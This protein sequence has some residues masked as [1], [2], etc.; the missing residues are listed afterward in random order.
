MLFVGVSSE[1]A[2]EEAKKLLQRLNL[3]EYADRYPFEL[4]GGQQQ[5]VGIA[6]AIAN[7]PPIIVADEPLGNLDSVNAKNV[8]EFLKELNE[9]DG[10]TIIMVTHEAWSLRDAKTIFHMKD[11]VMTEV[12][13]PKGNLASSLTE[14]L[15]KQLSSVVGGEAKKEVGQND[16]VGKV[17]EKEGLEITGGQKI[18]GINTE[19]LSAPVIANFL[20]RGYSLDE[21]N[22]FES[23]VGKLFAKE[24]SIEEFHKLI[25]KSYK[26]EGVGLWKKKAERIVKYLDE[27]IS[28][29]K[30]IE[31]I[32]KSIEGNVEVSIFD[33][34][35]NIRDWLVE[36]YTGE[37]SPMQISAL[38]Q[39]ISDRIRNLINHDDAV[40]VLSLSSKKFGVGLSLR[41]SH[42]IAEKLE[43]ILNGEELNK[44]KK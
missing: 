2:D 17:E 13:H 43:L 31:E 33:E 18:E 20:L 41:A 21:I 44:E 14:H 27:L 37:L 36:G 29:R 8:L 26:E 30:N 32:Y 15:N 42:L 16:V 19:K 3:M 7:D 6:R 12:E 25:N 4:S 1:K 23:F 9:K 34:V 22:R 24:I 40:K 35:K 10:R 11:G 28:E 5:R 39:V 38:D